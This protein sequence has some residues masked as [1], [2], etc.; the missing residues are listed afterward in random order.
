M[1]AALLLRDARRRAGLSQ[2]VLAER[3]GTSQSAIAAIESGRRDPSVGTLDRL[4]SACGLSARVRLLEDDHAEMV[5][6]L[7]AL[8]VR[9]RLEAWRNHASLRDRVTMVSS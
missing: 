3:A 8:D 4:L 1:D 9:E 6:A 7:L 2:R 5:A